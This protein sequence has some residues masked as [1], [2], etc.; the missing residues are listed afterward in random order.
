MET[1]FSKKKKI[2][3]TQWTI[4]TC[5]GRKTRAITKVFKNTGIKVAY[6]IK[7][8]LEKLRTS[9][10]CSITYTGQTGR[11]YK[12]RFQEH[13]RVFKY[14]TGKSSFAK[15]LLE[16]EH[17]I[18]PMEEIMEAVNCAKKGRLMDALG[19]FYIFRETKL[20]N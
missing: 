3:K 17:A 14:G 6:S 15:H 7:N 16:N 4:F 5:I 2:K 10:T 13:F 1:K 18:G 19:K 12:I 8:T 20:N 9:P 11:S